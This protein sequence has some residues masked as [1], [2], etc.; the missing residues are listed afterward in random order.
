M[1]KSQL[2]IDLRTALE[3]QEF[4]LYY[5]PKVDL[6]SGKIAGVEAL[7]RWDHPKRGLISPTEFIPLAEET[8]LISSIGEWALRTACAQS[9]AWQDIGIPPM[10]MAVNLSARQFYQP[11]L[12]ERIQHILEETELAPENLELEITESTIMDVDHILSILRELK[13]LV[14]G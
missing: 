14:C 3:R 12:V 10:I 9:K 4:H 11:D 6:A 13:E 1:D 2:E 5:Q 7:I 8:D